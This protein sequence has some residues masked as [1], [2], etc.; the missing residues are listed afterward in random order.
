[1]SQVDLVIKNGTV[2]TPGG[3]ISAGIAIKDGKIAAIMDN[4][5]L[6]EAEK[7]INATG[8][9]VLPGIIDP[10]VHYGYKHPIEDAMQG[11][12]EAA[13]A[14]GVTTFGHFLRSYTKSPATVMEN[15]KK[16]LEEKAIVDGFF[17]AMMVNEFIHD[18]PNCPEAGINSFKFLM[19]YKGPQA[20]AMGIVPIDDG[21]LYEGFRQIGELGRPAWAMVHAENIDISLVI[22]KKIEAEGRQDFPAWNDTRPR[23]VEEEAMRRAIFIA[24]VTNCP[25][26]IVHCTIAETAQIIAE[27]RAQGVEVIAETCPQYLTHSSEYPDPIFD[28]HPTLGNVN[29]PLRDKES[30]EKLWEG[31]RDGWIDVVASDYAPAT[32][33]QKG[34]DIWKAVMGVGNIT[35]MILPVMLSEG[36]NKGRITLE[37]LVEVCSYNPAKIFGLSDR[38]GKIAVG[39]DADIVLVDLEKKVRVTA[40][41]LHCPHCD[42]TIYEG[43]DIKG[44]PTMTLVRGNVVMEDGNIVGKPGNAQYIPCNCK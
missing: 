8:K 15:D 7:T 35:E 34:N 14:G 22:R 11:D 18:I 37:R 32:L 13:A 12:T 5:L 40:D 30:N 2:V 3:I 20:E 4:D 39:A 24:K 6:P 31:L 23:F 27:A 25:L 29:P 33:E 19:G 10:H 17:H 44:W 1:M 28:K 9:H 21:V 38:K 42:W 36:V 43:W 26:Y 16:V 41:M